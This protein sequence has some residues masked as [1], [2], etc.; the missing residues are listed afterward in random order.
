MNVLATQ[1]TLVLHATLQR[2]LVLMETIVWYATMVLVTVLKQILVSVMQTG[3][4]INAQYQNA[5]A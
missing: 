5:L 1:I 2:A 3:L 4:V